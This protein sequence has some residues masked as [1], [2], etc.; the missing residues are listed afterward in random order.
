MRAA[1]ARPASSGTGWAA[2]TT[3][4]RS[5][6]RAVAVAG[7][8]QARQLARPVPLQRQRPSRPRPCR[9]P[10]RSCAR[11]A[12]RAGVA[13]APRRVAPPRRR[14]RTAPAG[15]PA[16][17]TRL[18]LRRRG[19]FAISSSALTM[20][21]WSQALPPLAA[22]AL[23]SSMAVAVLGRL[24]PSAART[25]QCQAQILLVQ[26]DAEARVEGALDHPLAM[27]L[28]DA[29]RGEATHQR[30]AH[31]GRVGAGLGREHQRLGHRLDVERHDDLVGDLGGLA[32][33][34]AADQR[35][36][37]AHQLEQRLY[38]L[39]RGLGPADHDGERA[40]LAPTSPP[41]TGASR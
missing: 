31:L 40:A 6:G 11:A 10:P 16:A 32:V 23:N 27:H 17:S 2:S 13:G 9:R 12:A 37:L 25:G 38:P 14:R 21:E 4:I 19:W 29:R 22:Q 1:A 18:S 30:L 20:A 28:E 5:A 35:D 41:E 39:E 33:A 24:T 26:L 3:S 36:V 8:D 15:T 34:V 7:D